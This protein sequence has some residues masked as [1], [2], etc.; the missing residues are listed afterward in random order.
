MT[1]AVGGGAGSGHGSLLVESIKDSYYN[2]HICLFPIFPA[3]NNML[4]RENMFECYN[5]ILSLKTFLNDTDVQIIF[6]NEHLSQ[7]AL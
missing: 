6:D 3:Y 4:Y 1:L 5:T 7:M 2:K